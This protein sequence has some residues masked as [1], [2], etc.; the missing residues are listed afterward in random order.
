VR[1]ATSLRYF[2][3]TLIA[4]AAHS[5]FAQSTAT[6]PSSSAEA[7]NGEL[8]T[9]FVTA[10][11]RNERI[12]D[13]PITMSAFSGSTL[14]QLGAVKLED[15]ASSVS[16]VAMYKMA[17]GQPTWV[18]RGVGLTD[19]SPNNTPTAAIYQD[20]VY[21]TSN[22]MNQLSMFDIERVEVLKGPQGGL[23]GRNA[24]G[25]A[26]KIMSV[27]PVLGEEDRSIS[28]GLDNWKR[29]SIGA[30]MS[31]TLKP[32]TLATR[33]AF[34]ANQGIGGDAGPYK[35]VNYD[36]NY[37][38]P[39]N[40]AVRVSNLLKLSTGNSLTLIVDAARDQ[41]E[42]AR[43]TALGVYTVP[44]PFSQTVCAPLK[45]GQ[46][47]NSNCASYA[48]LTQIFSSASHTSDQSPSRATPGESSLS[49]PYGQYNIT[50]TGA[51]LQGQFKVKGLDLVS[52]TNLRTMDYGRT[53]DGDAS[54]GEYAHSDSMTKFKVGS[55]ELR[56]QHNEG[57]FK[58]SGGMSYAQDDLHEDR[59]FLFRDARYKV[60]SFAAYGVQNASELIA[61][62]RYDQVTKSSST[63]GQFDWGF[64]P[65]WNLGGSLRY[66]DE[67]KTYR[68]GGFGFDQHSG[69]V[70][71]AVAPIANNT[72]QADYQL[73]NHWSGGTSLRWQPNRQTTVY[74]SLQRGFKVGGF[75]GG[76]PLNGTAAI[77]PYK[78][79]TNDALE[80]GMKWAARDGRYGANTAVFQY[81]YKDA[82]AFT[83]VYSSLLNGPVTRLDNIG[84]AKHVGVELE[85]FW[86]P[87]DALRLDASVGYLDARFLDDKLYYTNDGK[88]ASYKDQQRIYAPKWSWTLR[89][90]YDLPLQSG[91]SVRM[92]M[93]VNGRT[94]AS[95]GAGSPVDAALQA[96]P[97][98]TLVNARI[99]YNAS[100]ERWQLAFY[101]KNLANTAVITS[102]AADGLSGYERLY[103]EPR[104]FGLEGRM[105]F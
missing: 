9:V 68:N 102:P 41:S 12:L 62:L 48:Q 20:D 37:G 96:L 27:K 79:E 1:I 47:D 86:R 50:N 40:L 58:W 66:T 7:A 22:A 97:G 56:L 76:F 64:A 65:L 103:G 5:V 72:L 8:Q 46:I 2:S 25:G 84:R 94:D 33:I 71:A 53:L 93:D 26:V 63:F 4:L 75:F 15:V 16:N 6:P 59:S 95:Q 78:E 70:A 87:T 83:T 67:T 54:Q 57:N 38:S 89:G 17:S 35:L 51:T 88:A 11:R 39:E 60:A 28:M 10:Q 105:S 99:A 13:V 90:Q 19:F 42:T 104:T 69:T 43:L 77:L 52:V 82:Q 100:S 81:N 34:K 85:T 80:L 92:S 61:T 91:A 30:A 45:A 73:N 101:A 23:Y 3:P 14:E 55:Q 49:D 21:L 44:P 29:A 24:S 18:I 74:G 31:T 32:D 98:Y 36:R